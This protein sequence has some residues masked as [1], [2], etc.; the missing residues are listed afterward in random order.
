MIRSVVIGLV[1]CLSISVNGQLS[2]GAGFNKDTVQIG[3]E[4]SYII[5][6][7]SNKQTKIVGV[8]ISQLDSII[9]LVQTK[10]EEQTDTTG[11]AGPVV[12]DYNLIST[13]NWNDENDDKK[14]DGLELTWDTTY[15]GDEIILQNTFKVSLWDAGPNIIA[16]PELTY[17]FG[18]IT[19]PYKKKSYSQIFVD[20]PF[21]E[22]EL[23]D[24]LDIAPIRTIIEEEKNITDY[25]PLFYALGVLL[26]LPLL[27]WIFKKVTTK[28]EEVIEEAVIIIPP[29]HKIALQ[30]LNELKISKLWQKGEVKEYQSQLTYTI[31]EYLENRYDIQALESST[32][33]I[34]KALKASNFD[35]KDEADLKTILQVADL[36]KFAKANPSG[37][38]HEEFLNTAFSFVEKTKEKEISNEEG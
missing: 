8:D 2:L 34:V 6:V 35:P 27:Y 5:S 28:K 12:G 25:Y 24:S 7:Q 3:E 20:V 14:I 4:V 15:R 30:K 31:R 29:A 17:Q 13:G 22:Q 16:T 11:E 18:G 19:S 37:E 10:M 9:S 1:L 32:D 23:T 26:L 36:V 38:I 33:E 21:E